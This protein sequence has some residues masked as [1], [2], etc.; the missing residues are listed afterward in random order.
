MTLGTTETHENCAICG[1]REFYKRLFT[2]PRGYLCVDCTADYNVAVAEICG[3]ARTLRA[4]L[5]HDIE[6]R[7]EIEGTQLRAVKRDLAR[8]ITNALIVVQGP[9]TPS[10]KDQVPY[11]R[12]V[13]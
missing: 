5:V 10:D 3:Y 8:Q 12:R 1:K 2:T 9:D 7:R 4:E 11:P 13:L 6:N